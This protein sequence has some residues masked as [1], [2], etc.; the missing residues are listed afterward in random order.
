MK[1]EQ[2]LADGEKPSEWVEELLQSLDRVLVE[3][4]KQ[5]VG[6]QMRRDALGS[7]PELDAADRRLV[8][9]IVSLRLLLRNGFA[10][11]MEIKETVQYIRLVDFYESSAVR[12]A[13]M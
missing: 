9:E 2:A 12:L 3:Q 4:G 7:I 11:A 10:L 6:D 5:P 1:A 13:R 8:E